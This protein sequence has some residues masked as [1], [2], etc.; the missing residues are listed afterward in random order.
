LEYVLALV[1]EVD[2]SL[3][4]SEGKTKSV[5]KPAAHGAGTQTKTFLDF[6]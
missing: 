4:A 6:Y 3:E 1:P 5:A 2:G